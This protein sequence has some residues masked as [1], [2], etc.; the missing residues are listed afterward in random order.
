[1]R[2]FVNIIILSN[3]N[4]DHQHLGFGLYKLINDPDT[5][6]TQLDYQEIGYS[7]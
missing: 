4:N 2:E 1:M 5:L 3:S 6:S 7:S